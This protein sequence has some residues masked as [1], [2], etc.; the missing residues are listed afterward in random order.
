MVHWMRIEILRSLPIQM[1]PGLWY[2]TKSG[3]QLFF[4][5]HLTCPLTR[6]RK[7][8]VPPLPPLL[9]RHLLSQHKL[10]QQVLGILLAQHLPNQQVLGIL[11]A[12]HLLN[13]QVLGIMLSQR[14]LN[15]QM[16]GIGCMA[17]FAAFPSTIMEAASGRLHNSGADPPLAPAPLLWNP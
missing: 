13:Q 16:L 11:L 12:Q 15:Q 5:G 7:C 4:C 1:P 10:N 8:G 17:I 14:L 9:T 3:L 6:R 2:G